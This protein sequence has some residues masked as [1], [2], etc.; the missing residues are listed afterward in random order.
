MFWYSFK[1]IKEEGLYGDGDQILQGYGCTH[2]IVWFGMLD[3]KTGRFKGLA[4]SRNKGVQDK[5]E[6]IT[7]TY[8]WH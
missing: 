7:I 2:T 6:C 3:S 8:K 4:D 1:N 5:L